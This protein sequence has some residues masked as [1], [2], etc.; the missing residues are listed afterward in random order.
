MR[1]ARPA[2]PRHFAFHPNGKHA[3]VIDEM[4]STVTAF[5]YDADK[6]VLKQIADRSRRCRRRTRATRRR[7]VASIRRASSSTAPTAA[8]TA[9]PS[10]PSTRRPA[11]LTAAGNQGKG[12]KTPRNFNIDPTGKYLLV[13]NQDG[14]SL[15]VFAI[16]PAT[17]K[18]K[19]TDNV[20]KV[21]KPVCVKFLARQPAKA[22]RGGSE[23]QEGAAEKSSAPEW[24]WSGSAKDNQ[25]AYFRKDI[26]VPAGYTS[27]KLHAACDN[28]FK[29]FIDGKAVADGS[30]WSEP[31]VK[32]VT[33]AFKSVEGKHL[34]AV[35]GHNDS[36]PAG[37]LVRLTFTAKGKKPFVVASD[38]TWLASEKAARGWRNAD[39][40]AKDWKP[41]TVV[42]KLGGGSSAQITEAFLS[43]LAAGGGGSAHRATPAA[44]LKVAKGFKAEL[45]YSVPK[46]KQGS[47]VNMCV[48]PKGRLIVSDQYGP[49]Y[50]ITPP[51][52]GGK[53]EDTKVEKLD[54]P[55]GEAQGL[56]WAFDSLYVMVNERG[57]QHADS[58]LYRVPLEGRRR[59]LREARV[60][61][62]DPAAA[63]STAPTP[64]FPARTA[65][66][67][68]SSAAT[69]RR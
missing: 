31:V 29:L 41:A 49:L 67:C 33:S 19:A 5:D 36:G 65:S 28:S 53:A 6:G 2:G 50:R 11:Q 16:D 14:N 68:T 15:C 17:G 48:D 34:I 38:A 7:S 62:Q 44:T 55:L 4:S 69:S 46:E 9:S 37:L 58:G 45:L 66:R 25:N 3:Y 26:D 23:E 60:A 40:D 32:D 54:L 59:H 52:I 64:S 61:A 43:G 20:V 30:E 18:L 10:S 12:I 57:R 13:A 22:V 8:T 47:W 1:H 63:A 51:A 56:L 27:V 39:Y 24:V 21:G 35:Q 42:A